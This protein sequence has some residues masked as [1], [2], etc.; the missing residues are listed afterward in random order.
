MSSFVHTYFVK[1]Q[2]LKH[3]LMPITYEKSYEKN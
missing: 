1:E 3:K 2:N